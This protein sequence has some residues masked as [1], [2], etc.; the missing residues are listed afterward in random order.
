MIS[1]RDFF[2]LT[3]ATGVGLAVAGGQTRSGPGGA[4]SVGALRAYAAA[5]AVGLS[6]P[7]A[8]PKFMNAVPDALAPGFIYQPDKKG[9]G[10][11]CQQDPAIFGDSTIHPWSKQG[12]EKT[13][14]DQIQHREL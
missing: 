9:R 12:G 7:A 13:D 2:K 14:G 8:Q 3:A 5:A 1:R 11:A 10:R 4:R 6:D